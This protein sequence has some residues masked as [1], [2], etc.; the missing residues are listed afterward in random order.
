MHDKIQEVL[1]SGE[2]ISAKCAELGKQISDEV[3]KEQIEEVMTTLTPREA[4]E[5]TKIYYLFLPL[6]FP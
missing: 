3:L 1:F 2:Q 4:I 5:L 6:I